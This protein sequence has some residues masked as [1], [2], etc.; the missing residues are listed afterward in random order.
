MFAAWEP[1]LTDCPPFSVSGEKL[2]SVSRGPRLEGAGR[3][4]RTS[5]HV[6]GYF[7]GGSREGPD[8][9][10]AFLGLSFS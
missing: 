2:I 4:V 9:H 3:C 5:G 1:G 6:T 7:T 10:N 8:K